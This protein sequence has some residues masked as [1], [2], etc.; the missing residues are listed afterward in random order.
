DSTLADVDVVI[1]DEFHERHLETDL[2]LA[3]LRELQT[4]RCDLKII[5]M[6]ATLDLKTINTFSDSKVIEI[7]SPIYPVEISYLPNQPSILNESLEL[8]VKKA[9]AEI[10]NEK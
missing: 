4:K 8:K 3:L 7:I 6:S 1:L 2:A 5:L 9:I 10:V